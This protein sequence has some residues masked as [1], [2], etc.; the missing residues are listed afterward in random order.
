M[1]PQHNSKTTNTLLMNKNSILHLTL[2]KLDSLSNG[3]RIG[4]KLRENQI[5]NYS[6]T[7]QKKKKR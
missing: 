3:K 7:R 1:N 2:G 6:V 5:L 4:A